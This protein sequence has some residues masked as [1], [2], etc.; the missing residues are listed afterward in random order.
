MARWGVDPLGN[1]LDLLQSS[2]VEN[3]LSAQT[4]LTNSRY[5][6]WNY[7]VQGAQAKAQ[8]RAA[9]IG[10]IGSAATS[11]LLGFKNPLSST[12]STV[13]QASGSVGQI[14]N[15]AGNSYLSGYS[16]NTAIV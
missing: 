12:T 5:Q 13:G 3:E 10:S 9:F 8:G 6:A 4:I 1:A 14:N 16:L 15:W 11:M 2:A 7:R